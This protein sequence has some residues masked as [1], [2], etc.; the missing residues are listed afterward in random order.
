MPSFAANG[1]ALAVDAADGGRITSLTAHGRQWL[2][3][4]LPRSA[5]ESFVV[6][7]T[8][9]WDEVAPT[10]QASTLPDGAVL[11]DHGDAWRTAWSVLADTPAELAM[12]VD[13]PSVG[14]R[15]ERRIRAAECGVRLDYRATSES[16]APV[17]LLWCAHPLFDA[18][19]GARIVAS[20]QLTGEYPERGIPVAWPAGVGPSALKAFTT[21]V[22]TASIA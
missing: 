7:G 22:T 3:P 21:G 15:L 13:L 20:G 2:A 17:P 5:A 11:R 16:A 12:A 19:G 8:G 10:V 1:I 9:G 6:A 18:S 14:V 4:S